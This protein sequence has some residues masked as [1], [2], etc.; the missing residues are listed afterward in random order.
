MLILCDRCGDTTMAIRVEERR[1]DV[2]RHAGT[3]YVLLPWELVR[4]TPEEIARR[5]AAGELTREEIVAKTE[6]ASLSHF[7]PRCAAGQ[8]KQERRRELLSRGQAAAAG[9]AAE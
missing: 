6:V 2:V 5:V 9:R 1:T 4:V 8:A 3:G 7:C